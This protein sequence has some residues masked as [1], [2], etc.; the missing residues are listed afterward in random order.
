MTKNVCL[1]GVG[2]LGSHIAKNLQGYCDTIY[3]VD[4]DI[5]EESNLKSS[6]YKKADI[7]IPKV[8]AL[9]RR[10]PKCHIIPVQSKIE[11]V[12]IPNA[13]QIID[14]RDVVNRN[15]E[16]DFKFNVVEKHLQ[17]N[18]EPIVKE[19][20]RPGKYLLELDNRSLSQAGELTRRLLESDVIDTILDTRTKVYLPIVS[21]TRPI[22]DLVTYKRPNCDFII[23]RDNGN[24]TVEVGG[25]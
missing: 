18:C 7:G 16:S 25:A 6:I 9:K 14:C 23:C 11:S 1:I 22:T 24:C 21:T 20:D 13:N 12:T 2:S 8:M 17:V 10:I 5:V 4:P 19:K 15:I 3:A